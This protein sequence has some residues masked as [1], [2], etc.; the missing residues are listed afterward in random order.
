MENNEESYT[1]FVVVLEKNKFLYQYEGDGT[2]YEDVEKFEKATLYSIEQL[3]YFKERGFPYLVE[4]I[5]EVKVNKTNKVL[6][7]DEIPD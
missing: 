4:Q 3:Q 6:L 2:Y 7:L 1:K 5:I